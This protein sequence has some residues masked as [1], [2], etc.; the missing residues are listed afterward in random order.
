MANMDKLT[1]IL[2]SEECVNA[3]QECT[4]KEA[5]LAFLNDKGADVTEEDMKKIV[6]AVSG[7]QALSD[8]VLAPVSGGENY[9]GPQ[10][11][12]EAI[13]DVLIW[14]GG[15]AVDGAKYIWNTNKTIESVKDIWNSIFG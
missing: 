9:D 6:A 3:L 7:K 1:E 5:V 12:G 8:E 11:T 15:K 14:V 10:T 4:T 13:A 2:S